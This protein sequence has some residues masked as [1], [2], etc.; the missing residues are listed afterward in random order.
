ML[1][2]SCWFIQTKSCGVIAYIRTALIACCSVK[3]MTSHFTSQLSFVADAER[4]LNV[5]Y[6]A[7]YWPTDIFME[8]R[9]SVLEVQLQFR[10][11]VFC[12]SNHVTSIATTVYMG[13]VMLPEGYCNR[14]SMLMSLDTPC[15]AP[16][17]KA[18]FFSDKKIRR[19]SERARQGA[20]GPAV[21]FL[22][23]RVLYGLDTAAD[24]R[25]WPA[26][27]PTRMTQRVTSN[28]R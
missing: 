7:L 24:R 28:G 18:S 1:F 16:R 10:Y 22:T 25:R 9:K 2:A 17:R 3:T 14:W 21:P 11:M 8:S 6:W 23:D 27:R 13:T 12:D 20:V 19:A 15:F 26:G 4:E 5:V